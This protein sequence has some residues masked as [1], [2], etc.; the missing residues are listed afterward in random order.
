MPGVLFSQKLKKLAPRFLFPLH[1]IVPHNYRVEDRPNSLE[2]DTIHSPDGRRQEAKESRMGV[3]RIHD[4]EKFNKTKEC[5]KNNPQSI[6]AIYLPRN[7]NDPEEKIHET[8][9]NSLSDGIRK[10]VNDR[11]SPS[12]ENMYAS[13]PAEKYA[14][15]Q[16]FASGSAG[17]TVIKETGKV[18]TQVRLA[19][20]KRPRNQYN[21]FRYKILPENI[22]DTPIENL[23]KAIQTLIME[24]Y[25]VRYL[26]E[27]EMG[28]ETSEKAKED[29][30]KY[31]EKTAPATRINLE[32]VNKFLADYDPEK[33]IPFYA[34]PLHFVC[35]TIRKVFGSSDMVGLF[36]T[37]LLSCDLYH[38]IKKKYLSQ[39]DKLSGKPF[40][41]YRGKKMN[42]RELDALGVPG[43]RI[44]IRPFLSTTV[45]E[46][47]AKLFAGVGSAT[48]GAIPVILTMSIGQRQIENSVL[49]FIDQISAI[50]PEKEVLLGTG[51]VFRVA[52]ITEVGNGNS[53]EVHI[54]LV[55][56]E[57]EEK[58]QES[59]RQKWLSW[60]PTAV[61][62]IAGRSGLSAMIYHLTLK[63]QANVTS[64]PT[65]APGPQQSN[66]LPKENFADKPIHVNQNVI[67]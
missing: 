61:S 26:V 14:N 15:N 3:E 27:N 38:Q 51:F 8:A 62:S 31:C 66:Y 17:I 54:S 24:T 36:D 41:C 57:D 2:M 35:K 47:V 32:S 30:K 4:V 9:L 19:E 20:P 21:K 7:A 60:L 40:S 64:N 58:L 46:D 43:S 25:L 12:Q 13:P 5:L 56:T 10:R 23:E 48:D 59:L 55:H 16:E 50:E 22:L 42:K 63:A 65:S 34:Q 29:L 37:R 44:M 39:I 53:R 11:P 6:A 33:I 67:R 18:K 1:R 28:E 45:N 52:S 49:A